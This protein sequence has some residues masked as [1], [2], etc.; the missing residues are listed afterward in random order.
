MPFLVSS[1]ATDNQHVPY[2]TELKLKITEP[3]LRRILGLYTLTVKGQP[4]W[5]ATIDKTHW[6][7]PF[8]IFDERTMGYIFGISKCSDGLRRRQKSN[9]CGE[10]FAAVKTQ[11]D[12]RY[13][14]ELSRLAS[15]ARSMAILD[16]DAVKE[17][18]EQWL[19]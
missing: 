3:S 6:L 18:A 2:T 5:K 10:G 4:H 14:A 1:T 12:W 16:L 7:Y 17:Y 8:A 19:A 9:N 15:I 13:Y 11:I